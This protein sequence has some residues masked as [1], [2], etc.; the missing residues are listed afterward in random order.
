MTLENVW[1]VSK[2]TYSHDKQIISNNHT[3]VLLGSLS[4]STNLILLSIDHFMYI[5][6]TRLENGNENEKN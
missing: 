5:R 4:F 2:K 6:L 3:K 1:T